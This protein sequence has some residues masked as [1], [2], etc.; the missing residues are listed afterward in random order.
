MDQISKIKELIEPSL[1][2]EKVKLYDVKWINDKKNRILQVSITKEDG[3]MDIDTCALVSENISL[4]L[5][6]EIDSQYL[7]EVCSPG[8]ER[9]IKDLNEL[10]SLIGKHVFVRLKHAIK[11][12]NEYQGDLDKVDSSILLKY[13]DRAVYKTLEFNREEIEFIRLAVNI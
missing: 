8:A 5:D 6:D 13:K 2:L 1:T 10:E 4:V 3:S 11:G 7:L 12:K 9:E